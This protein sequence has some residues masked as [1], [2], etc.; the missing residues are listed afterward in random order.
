MVG[1]F[2]VDFW[3]LVTA[4]HVGVLVVNLSIAA[5]LGLDI[6]FYLVAQPFAH[7][8]DLVVDAYL[9]H[10]V[11]DHLVAA[12]LQVAVLVGALWFVHRGITVAADFLLVV[13]RL[14]ATARVAFRS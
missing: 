5:E 7:L 4:L 11:C 12:T 13:E 6:V 2:V 3:N 10:V 14:Q 1:G 8:L 9:G